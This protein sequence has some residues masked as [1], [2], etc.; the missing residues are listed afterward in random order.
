MPGDAEAKARKA[1]RRAQTDFERGQERLEELRATRRKRFEE[2]QA[3][4]LSMRDIAKE[5][6]LHFTRVAQILRR[7]TAS[8]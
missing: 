3:A 8:P 1:V 2:A 4:G 7:A 6:G 5:T